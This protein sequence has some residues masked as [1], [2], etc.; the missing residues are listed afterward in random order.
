MAFC[1]PGDLLGWAGLARRSPC[2]WI[3]ASSELHLIGFNAETFY[4]LESR[5]DAFRKWLDSNNS[6]AELISVIQKGLDSRTL[7]EPSDREVLRSLVPHMKLL[8]ARDIRSLPNDPSTIHLW[9]SQVPD[10]DLP[11]GSP[12][13]SSLLSSLPPDYSLLLYAIDKDKWDSIFNVIT[14]PDR[15]IASVPDTTSEVH[16]YADLML[17]TS[18]TVSTSD[19]LVNNSSNEKPFIYRGKKL[20]VFTGT[21]PLQESIAVLSMISRF[22]NVPFRRDIVERAAR[23]ALRVTDP[24]L[25]IIGNLSTLM[26]FV[27]TISIKSLSSRVSFPYHFRQ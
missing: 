23:D 16:R 27:G 9:N 2:E 18:D 21:G 15:P 26:G 6:P 12:V 7:A 8:P 11:I 22:Y 13:T 25:E 19:L 24:T 4:E 1:Q 17:D 10:F 3:T 5:S 20:P 14:A